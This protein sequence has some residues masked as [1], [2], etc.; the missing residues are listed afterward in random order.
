VRPFQDTFAQLRQQIEEKKSE[1]E[2]SVAT[3]LYSLSDEERDLLVTEPEKVLPQMAA[4]VHLNAVTA[5]LTQISQR[6]PAM[7]LTLMEVQKAHVQAEDQFWNQFPTLNRQTDANTVMTLMKTYRQ[8]NPNA[9]QEEAIKQVGAM[10]VVA[11]G[12]HLQPNQ[13]QQAPASQ[14]V[15]RQVPARTAFQPA[16][17]GQA[18]PSQ[19]K[20]QYASEWDRTLAG[21]QEFEAGD[22]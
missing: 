17:N 20:P 11:L 12:K 8:A 4:R 21:L 3:Q 16:G 13:Q 15:V 9:T 2:G 7:V 10:A 22:M 1:I 6:L 19:A 5:V 14:P 18:V